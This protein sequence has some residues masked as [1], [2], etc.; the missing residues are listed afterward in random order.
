M[1]RF[2]IWNLKKIDTNILDSKSAEFFYFF[3]VLPNSQY[4]I[5][6]G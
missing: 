5:A 2:I 3:C 1:R 4:Y 6:V